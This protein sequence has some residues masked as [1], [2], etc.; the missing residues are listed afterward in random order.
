[1]DRETND[2]RGYTMDRQTNDICGYA[3]DRQTN[4]IFG[5]NMDR[6]TK[7][8]CGYAMDR[9]TNDI[10]QILSGVMPLTDRLTKEATYWSVCLRQGIDDSLLRKPLKILTEHNSYSYSTCSE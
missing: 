4:D 7:D 5:Y 3:M 8:F 1:M 2:I 6:Q 9:L 10:C